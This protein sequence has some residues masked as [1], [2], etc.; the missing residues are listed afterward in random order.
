MEAI[1]KVVAYTW[2]MLLLLGCLVGPQWEKKYLALKRL[3]A[4]G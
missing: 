3:E 4:P 1:P 2:Y